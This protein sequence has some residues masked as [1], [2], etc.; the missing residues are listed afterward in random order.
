MKNNSSTYID[1]C[2][3][4]NLFKKL[5]I[6]HFPNFNLDNT[7]YLDEIF[8]LMSNIK[9]KGKVSFI[10]ECSK[11]FKS[12]RNGK[13]VSKISKNY[14]ISLGWSEDDAISK[15]SRLQS[16]RSFLTED[17][18]TN[19]GYSIKESK[20]KIKEIQS[21]NSKK[22]YNKYTKAELTEQSV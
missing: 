15:V 22:R 7:K 11:I 9:I 2:S 1:S 12:K 3:D 16:I 6:E 20:D 18:W 19:K 5:L 14:W 8:H 10:K 17:Y 4:F 21:N 13:G